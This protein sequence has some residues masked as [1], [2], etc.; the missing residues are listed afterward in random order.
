MRRDGTSFLWR[1]EEWESAKSPTRSPHQK[2]KS[3]RQ[4]KLLAMME[5]QRTLMSEAPE[6]LRQ[7]TFQEIGNLDEKI[8]GEETELLERKLV[9]VEISKEGW[10]AE[11][12]A[13]RVKVTAGGGVTPKAVAGSRSS[14]A[15]VEPFSADVGGR[16]GTED[17]VVAGSGFT[18]KAAGGSQSAGT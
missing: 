14:E 6:D 1:V 4:E 12:K 10:I 5:R 15:E 11:V 7:H 16:R 18:R 17:T 2:K 13:G 9:L 8:S 3:E